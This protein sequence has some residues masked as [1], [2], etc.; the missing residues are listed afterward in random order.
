MTYPQY[1][2]PDAYAVPPATSAQPSGGTAITAGVLATLGGLLSL[3][4]TAVSLFFLIA[5]ATIGSQFKPSDYEI[6]D[7]I[8]GVLAIGMVALVIIAFVLGMLLSALLITGAVLLFRRKMLGRWLVV[9]GCAVAIVSNLM[10]SVFTSAVTSDDW[11]A[12][13]SVVSAF[14]GLAFPI[15]TMVLVLLPSTTVWI[16]AEPTRTVPHYFPQYPPTYQS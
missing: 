7:S 9:S 1:P 8:F 10:T 3:G 13:Q 4:I 12:S 11:H 16:R 14:V 2:E 15:A 5:I 6:L